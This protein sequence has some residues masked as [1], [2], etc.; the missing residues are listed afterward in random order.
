MDCTTIRQGKHCSFMSPN[1]CTYNGGNC[2]EIVEQCTGC[3]R[4]TEITTGWFC[5]A[6]PDPAMKWKHGN[7]NLATHIASQASATKTKINPLKASKRS[8][9]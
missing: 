7:C 6:Y 1:G 8:K 9:R 2:H 5:E 3:K 4:A